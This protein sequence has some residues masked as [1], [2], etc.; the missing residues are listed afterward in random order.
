MHSNDSSQST[1]RADNKI[2]SATEVDGPQIQDIAAR[3]GVFSLEEVDCV[4]ELWQEYLND[5]P[6]VCG[7]NFI[8]YREDERVLGFACYGPRDLTHGAYDLYWIAVDRDARRGGV[9]RVLIVASEE[10]ARKGGG[11]LLIAETSGTPDYE[12][13]RNFYLGMGYKAE[14]VIKD[15][16]TSGDDL[17][18]FIKRL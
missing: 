9:G 2:I 14:A 10:A 12:P 17:F 3:A 4:S 13:T 7:Y 6:E 8:V 5:G 15:F 1:V 16:Y 11:R 18:I